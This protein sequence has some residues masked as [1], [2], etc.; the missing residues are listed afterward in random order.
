M[1][2]QQA[3]VA[4]QKAVIYA[5]TALTVPLGYV[6]KGKRLLVGDVKKRNNTIIAVALVGRVGWIKVRDIKFSKEERRQSRYTPK[7][8]RESE[9]REF[10][11]ITKPKEYGI[12]VHGYLALSSPSVESTESGQTLESQGEEQTLWGVGANYAFN[13]TDLSG[14]LE[15]QKMSFVANR[16]DYSLLNLKASLS[17]KAIRWSFFSIDP[18]IGILLSPS[19]EVTSQEG[20]SV[21]S[22]GFGFE[23]GLR[24]YFFPKKD[25]QPFVGFSYLSIVA[26]GLETSNFLSSGNPYKVDKIFSSQVLLGLSYRF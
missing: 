13:D 22:A 14:E 26:S 25:W 12:Q 21:S 8:F 6:K 9:G 2:E 20:A 4:V 10:R 3:I 23:A 16:Y 11:E 18:S 17:Y 5:D 24:S 1:A 7:R 15:L 19:V